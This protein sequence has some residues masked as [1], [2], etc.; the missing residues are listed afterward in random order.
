MKVVALVPIKFKSQRLENKNILPL[1]KYPLCWYIFETLKQVKRIDEIYVYC[2][3]PHITN[4][5]PKNIKFLERPSFLD[6][7]KT[8]GM[9]IYTQFIKEVDADIYILAH[10]TS[11]FLNSYSIQEG[12]DKVLYEDYDSAFSVQKQK[13]Y[14]WYQNNPINYSL[15]NIVRTQELKPLYMETSAFYI[16]K[17]N[18]I[19]EK[20]QR[21]GDKPYKVIT[22]RIESIDID[23]IDD[24]KL[25][26]SVISSSDILSRYP[27][28]SL[29]LF[30]TKIN[31]IKIKTV[32]LDYDGTLSDGKIYFNN[33][34]IY[35]KFYNAKDGY[36]LNWLKQNNIPIH[37]ISGND[38]TFFKTKANQFNI[39]LHGQISDKIN[40]ALTNIF[41][42]Q[43][44][45]E[46][47]I[48][49]GD[50]DNDIPLLQHVALS[51][52]PNNASPN[53]KKICDYVSQYDGG[54][55]AVRD[56]LERVFIP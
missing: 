10:A 54:E 4:Y 2:S 3:D 49:I 44:L 7:D 51:A 22:D 56:I 31:N 37:I 29:T 50:D 45:P 8:I 20:Q 26:Q 52:C 36:M 6:N 42:N 15:N 18:I 17:Q 55:G 32:I 30:Q 1:G 5:I 9:E 24:Y 23:E 47:T 28:S 33:Q 19:I 27:V 11:P 21:I 14:C 53:V 40:Y 39:K 34:N 25:A 41:N 38:L 43:N 16:F 13:T 35:S 12:L 48:Y 46:N